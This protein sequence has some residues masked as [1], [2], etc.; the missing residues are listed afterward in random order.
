MSEGSERRSGERLGLQLPV[1][2]QGLSRTGERWEEMTT[3]EDISAGGAAFVLRHIVD[4]GQALV[5]SLPLPKRYRTFDPTTPSYRVFA[6]VR[7]IEPLAEGFRLGVMFI[8]KNPPRGFEQNPAARYLLP[9]DPKPPPPLAPAAPEAAPD[10]RRVEPRFQVFLNLK[11]QR[12][13]D[14]LGDLE[15]QTVAENLSRRGVQVPTGLPVNKGEVVWIEEIGGEFKLRA[16]VRNVFIGK[17]QV[18]RLNLRFIDGEI[19]ER[20]IAR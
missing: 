18:P 11:L 8:G 15:E 1:R 20:L 16:E 7:K 5:L 4:K 14:A 17:D 12:P 9:G 3:G 13:P 2:V 10:E 19:P 6:L